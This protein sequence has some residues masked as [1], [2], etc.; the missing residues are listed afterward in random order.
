MFY[1]VYFTFNFV[2]FPS[3]ILYEFFIVLGKTP[4]KRLGCY[5]DKGGAR[6][7]PDLLFDVS[8]NASKLSG[9]QWGVYLLEMVCKCAEQA[10]QR[11]YTHFGLQDYGKCYS[12][13]NVKTTY[14][15]ASGA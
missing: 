6:P 13:S 14:D 8:A 3:L 9:Q 15:K 1:W 4:Y 7:L 10:K 5:S 12:G 11:K 2:A